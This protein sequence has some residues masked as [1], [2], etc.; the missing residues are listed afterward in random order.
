MNHAARIAV[1]AAVLTRQALGGTWKSVLLRG[2]VVVYASPHLFTALQP[3]PYVVP[4]GFVGWVGAAWWV[5]HPDWRPR[6]APDAVAEGP[7]PE[8]EEGPEEDPV[9]LSKE[10]PPGPDIDTVVG[11]AHR[12]GTP[13]VHLT[14]IE[15]HLGA[16]PGSVRR[17]L[18]AAGIPI[19]DVRMQGR[20]TSTGVKGH[21]LPPLSHP[22]PE[23]VDGVVGA[24]QGANN[25]NNITVKSSA[26]GVRV[27]VTD[28]TER[29]AYTV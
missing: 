10:H 29:R 7:G 6:P 11:A 22:S 5:G 14:A 4:V 24:G 25:S 17:V 26:N 19:S 23:G 12:L 18:T 2:G 16:P 8:S 13:H 15:D 21:D 20:G 28:L 3:Y 9:S 1:G 27:T